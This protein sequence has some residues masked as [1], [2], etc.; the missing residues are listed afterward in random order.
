L[1]AGVPDVGVGAEAATSL[2]QGDGQFLFAGVPPG[3]YTI[4][5]SP[6]ISAYSY[7]PAS[8]LMTGNIPLPPG[9]AGNVLTSSVSAAPSGMNLRTTGLRDEPSFGR[10]EVTIDNADVSD[11]RVVLASGGVISGRIEV[12]SAP[13]TPAGLPLSLIVADPADG[14]PALGRPTFTFDRSNPSPEFRIQGLKP[15]AYLLDVLGGGL[16]KSVVVDQ[17]D[18]TDRPLEVA[19]GTEITGVVV[20]LTRRSAR[21]AGYVRDAQGRPL[22]S[23]AVVLC[24][25][26]DPARRERYGTQPKRLRAA[27]MADDGGY[28]LNNLPAGDYL[29]AALDE[30]YADAWHDATFLA[31][32]APLAAKVRLDWDQERNESLTLLQFP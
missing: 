1:A 16:V 19:G 17:R 9:M 4:V 14:D 21:L 11:A 20:T 2:A 18:H 7:T 12:E 31:K 22:T 32:V 3:R 26:A 15:G 25:P 10:T 27:T 29:L 24:F 30:A 13:G 28:Q 8:L 5:T 23:N 6:S